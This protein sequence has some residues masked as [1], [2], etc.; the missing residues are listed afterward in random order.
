MT[1]RAPR[2]IVL[3]AAAAFAAAAAGAGAADVAGVG[4]GSIRAT[5]AQAGSASVGDWFQNT[6][7]STPLDARSFSDILGSP[8]QTGSAAAHAITVRAV[9]RTVPK[10]R[11]A[12]GSSS[13]DVLCELVER[14]AGNVIDRVQVTVTPRQR[15]TIVNTAVAILVPGGSVKWRCRQQAS[16]TQLVRL[17]HGRLIDVVVANGAKV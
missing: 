4:R 13:I 7:S 9:A 2:G 15:V 12:T 17:E 5:A 1:V 3:A 10:T 16:A 11:S 8:T 14:P 6:A